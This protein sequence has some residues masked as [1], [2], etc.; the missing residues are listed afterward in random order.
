MRSSRVALR[1]DGLRLFFKSAEVSPELLRE[2][3]MIKKRLLQPTVLNLKPFGAVMLLAVSSMGAQICL[4]ER[5]VFVSF[6]SQTSC[7][8][9][10]PKYNRIRDSDE[11]LSEC[12]KSDPHHKY[13][14][15]KT[16]E[17]SEYGCVKKPE[18]TWGLYVKRYSKTDFAIARPPAWWKQLRS[19]SEGCTERI[20]RTA[21]EI[22]DYSLNTDGNQE[23]PYCSSTEKTISPARLVI[24]QIGTNL[25]LSEI[26]YQVIEATS[27][28]PPGSD[29]KQ[30][31]TDRQIKVVSQSEDAPEWKRVKK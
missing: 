21:S 9:N 6:N 13:F 12:K 1:Q 23:T 29:R 4:A 8:Q 14:Y 5:A 17:V 24:R 25:E 20:Y 22:R 31:V 15:P 26:A 3:Q 7:E 2:R 27:Y 11:L 28:Y 16:Q 30:K 18:G 19:G 10:A